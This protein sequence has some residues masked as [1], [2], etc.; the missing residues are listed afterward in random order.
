[1]RRVVGLTAVGVSLFLLTTAVMGWF[2]AP[3]ALKKTPLDTDSWTYLAGTATY[4]DKGPAPVKAWSHNRVDG[5]AST[6]NVAVFD[7]VTCLVWDEGSTWSDGADSAPCFDDTDSRL[8]NGPADPP[9]HF[10][11]DRTSGLS[12]PESDNATYKVTLTHDGLVNK[13]PFSTQKKDYP[14]WDGVLGRAVTA[15]YSG[16]EKLDGLDTYTFVISLADEGAEIAKDTMGT[17]SLDKTMWI[18]PA[19]G[20]IIK[21]SEHQVRTL[22]SG[23]AALDMELAFTDDQVA[24]NVSSAKSSGGL[25]SAALTVAPLAAA[26]VGVLAGV[27]AL[28]MLRPATG[29]GRRRG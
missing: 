20:S 25:L 10:A 11:A 14:F 22:D 29:G 16:T 2:Y 12:L 7:A 27:L 13:F 5:G 4:L 18:D 9:D 21:Q 3:G 26:V 24:R 8:I 28:V 15:T 23:D 1:M 6:D 19:T 17:Y